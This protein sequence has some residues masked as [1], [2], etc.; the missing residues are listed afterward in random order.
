MANRTFTDNDFQN[1]VDAEWLNEVNRLVHVIFQNP[2]TT[3]AARA[4]LGLSDAQIATLYHNQVPILAQAAVEA[5]ESAEAG[6]I[7]PLR[8]AQAIA[9]LEGERTHRR[10]YLA[11]GSPHTWTK[12]DH[13]GFAGVRVWVVGGGGGGGGAERTAS[14]S[15]GGTGGGG[16][17]AFGFLAAASLGATE[18]VTVGAAGA[19]G[20]GSANGT[21]GGTSSFGAHISCTG[22]TFGASSLDGSGA[23]GLGGS[24]S[25][26]DFR[27]DG[28]VG[29]SGG[30][31]RDG[32]SAG[33]NIGP[34][35]DPDI[36]NSGTRAGISGILGQ[37][38]GRGAI[39]KMNNNLN[40]ADGYPFGG[41]GGAGS[42]FTDNGTQSG[43]A[44]GP[45]VVVI[46]EIYE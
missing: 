44:G 31:E 23:A 16:A 43:G 27:A 14:N 22:G 37:W 5:G 29:A 26:G 32:G 34:H 45:G 8:L 38:A 30:S 28:G 41:G 40:G 36:D 46:E 18:T 7:S 1:P 25:G 20:V 10:I 21:S 42:R 13:S 9:A 15:R 35:P 6:R 3:A 33:G 11:A 2:G 39:R 4:A 19:G 12:P 24:A 17:A